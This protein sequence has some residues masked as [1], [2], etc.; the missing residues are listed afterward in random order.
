M[1][2]ADKNLRVIENFILHLT[3]ASDAS[4]SEF[5]KPQ[6]Y[7]PEELYRVAYD[8]IEEDHVD[9]RGNIENLKKIQN[10]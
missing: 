10:D 5:R 8:Y 9:G 4:D 1:T 3:H 7:T 6:I 2:Q